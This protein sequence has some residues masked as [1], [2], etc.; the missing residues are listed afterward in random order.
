[1]TGCALPGP[2]WTSMMFNCTDQV[3]YA[4]NAMLTVIPHNPRVVVGGF[5][6]GTS[7]GSADQQV[8]LAI[9]KDAGMSWSPAWKP[10]P[11]NNTQWCPVLFNDPKNNTLWMFYSE[12]LAAGTANEHMVAYAALSEDFGKTWYAKREILDSRTMGSPKAVWV[13]NKIVVLGDG[14][15]LLPS[16]TY[17]PSAAF[18]LVT[19]DGGQT[20]T[21]CGHIELQ[22]FPEPGVAQT[23]NGLVA[24]IRGPDVGMYTA[25]S[26]NNGVTWSNASLSIVQGASSKPALWR[27]MGSDM[28]I[29]TYNIA[30]RLVLSLARSSEF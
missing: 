16:D 30:T 29:L 17:E 12:E 18:F 21:P 13:L 15:W 1:M 3:P 22:G 2:E 20:W 28:I 4:H 10:M 14:F 24:V 19:K 5:Q 27:S 6:A 11:S 8:Y 9:S 7:E 26:H 25:Y 23:K